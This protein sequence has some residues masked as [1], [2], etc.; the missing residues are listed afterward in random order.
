M[1]KSEIRKILI[2]RHYIGNT[3]SF[4]VD[5]LKRDTKKYL[6]SPKVVL[7][8]ESDANILQ[9]YIANKLGLDTPNIY[10]MYNEAEKKIIVMGEMELPKEDSCEIV[11]GNEYNSIL[12]FKTFVE[13]CDKLGEEDRLTPA[14][15]KIFSDIYSKGILTKNDE[16]KPADEFLNSNY[17]GFFNEYFEKKAIRDIIKSRIARITTFDRNLV[18]SAN[19][20][21]TDIKTHKVTDVFPVYNNID[22]MTIYSQ[23]CNKDTSKI[24]DKYQSEFSRKALPLKQLIKCMKENDTVQ[25]VFG[26]EGLKKLGEDLGNIS[27]KEYEKEYAEISSGYEICKVYSDFVSSKINEVANELIR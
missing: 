21:R 1:D 24:S 20:Y 18:P 13:L 11:F 19:I 6:E 17:Q 26:K 5:K 27:T 16:A 9:G 4:N 2:F 7:K 22:R 8:E 14:E 12:N 23:V 10:P 25:D 3:K 15:E